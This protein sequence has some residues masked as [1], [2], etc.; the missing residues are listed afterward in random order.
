MPTKTRIHKL[1]CQQR[2]SFTSKIKKEGFDTVQ[3]KVGGF[4]IDESYTWVKNRECTTYYLYDN[5]FV[6]FI[7]MQ[8]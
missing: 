7:E 5:I 8:E 1:K 4:F 3:W 2:N 6:N